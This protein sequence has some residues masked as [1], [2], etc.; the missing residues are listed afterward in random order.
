MLE[1]NLIY[2]EDCLMGMQKI[3]DKSI[4]M[5]LCDLPYGTTACKWDSIIDLDK[6]WIEYKR[7]IK[8]YGAIIL[9]CSQPFTTKL[10]SSN[11]NWFKYCWVWEK[12]RATGHVHSK[13]RPMKIHED[14]AVFSEGNTLH[15]GQSNK[16]MPYY[17]QG[18]IELGKD[19]YRRT[20][21]DAGDNA[22]M[23]KRKS[24]K[25]TIATHTG[26][27]TSILNFDIEMNEQRFHETQKPLQLCEYLIKT[28]SKENEL[29]LDNCMGG[30]N[31]AIAC[32]NTNRNYIGF[33]LESTYCD[34]ANKR[35][36]DIEL[37]T[38]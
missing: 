15:E 20:R 26:Y 35:I 32:I 12:N 3:D 25:E 19:T 13:N 21:H 22:V 34:I 37:K 38:Q 36:Q 5:I 23:G 27:P 11:Y 7:I 14:V 29:I 30:G 16:R 10:I 17:P 9:F 2:N 18:L 33:E 24:H 31:T 6:L 4:D 8:P 28:Y 1:I